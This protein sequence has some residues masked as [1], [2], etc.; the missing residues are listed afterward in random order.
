MHINRKG[1]QFSVKDT[2]SLD[3]VLAPIIASGLRKFLSIKS[4]NSEHFGI[5]GSVLQGIN[6]ADELEKAWCYVGDSKEEVLS[7]SHRRLVFNIDT[8]CWYDSLYDDGIYTN[9]FAMRCSDF[10]EES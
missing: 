8:S 4:L 9:N 7:K 3:S 2:W 1:I 10:G 6:K 5:P